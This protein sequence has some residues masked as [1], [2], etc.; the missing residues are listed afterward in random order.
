MFVEF[1]KSRL[2]VIGT[3]KLNRVMTDSVGLSGYRIPN[4]QYPAQPY[5]EPMMFVM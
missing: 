5:V 4:T 1:F 2:R 3:E